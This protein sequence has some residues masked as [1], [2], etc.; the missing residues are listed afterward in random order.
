MKNKKTTVQIGG[1]W[2]PNIGNAFIDL[3]SMHTLKKALN[4]T[5]EIYISSNFPKSFLARGGFTNPE[6]ILDG[7]LS[8][9][10]SNLFDVREFIKA[11]YLVISGAIL[12]DLWIK[13]CSFDRLIKRNE[14]TKLIINGGGGSLYSENEIQNTRSFLKR[15]KPYA[16]ISRDERTFKEYGDLAEHSFSGIDCGFFISDCIQPPSLEFPRFLTF[17]FDKFQEPDINGDSR[18]VVRTHH[19]PWSQSGGIFKHI[20]Y[21][22]KQNFNKKNVLIS[23]LPEDYLIIYANTD[24]THSDR[25]HA[26]VPTLAYGKP[27]RFYGKTPRASLFDRIG[28]GSLSDRLTKIDMA[29]LNKEKNKHIT[30]LTE[31]LDI[32]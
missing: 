25:V 11:D 7:I 26:C 29:S 23:D 28:A 8:D 21:K 12:N 1:S 31:L 19:S 18:M 6:R 5:S 27:A 4:N 2:P 16:L 14:H 3:G 22:N 9:K 20:Y 32:S 17:S 10:I 15:L 24:E 13:T 30:F